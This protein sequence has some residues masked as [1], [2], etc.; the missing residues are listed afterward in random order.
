MW[1]DVTNE[2]NQDK[3]ASE[4]KYVK[5]PEGR[6]KMRVLDDEPKS[7]WRHF[8]NG[9]GCNN[10]KGI[11]VNCIGK[12]CPVCAENKKAKAA[13]GKNK[14]NT[15]MSHLI[16]VLVIEIQEVGKPAKQVNEVMLLDKGNTI[17]S[18]MADL[19]S[20]GCNLK[21]RSIIITKKGKKFNEITYTVNPTLNEESLTPEQIEIAKDTYDLFEVDKNLSIEDLNT[22]LAGGT[23]SPTNVTVQDN[24]NAGT[25]EPLQNGFQ[26]KSNESNES[27]SVDFTETLIEY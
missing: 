25:H 11:G 4:V 1:A 5:L 26:N 18:S 9:N 12:G 21:E 2:N 15:S 3:S 24:P 10:G 8:I 19:I 20:Q 7:R 22:L 27:I 17:F 23:L 13:T 6:V 16:N 14:Y